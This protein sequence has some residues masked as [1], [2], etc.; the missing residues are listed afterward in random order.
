MNDGH[1]LS[2]LVEYTNVEP[3][4]I[5]ELRAEIAN[6]ARMAGLEIE[7]SCD[8]D[9]NAEIVII[10]EAPGEQERKQGRPLVG[11]SGRKLWDTLRK[12]GITRQQCYITNVVKRQVSLSPDDNS[13]R[14]AHKSEVQHWAG[15]LRWEL[16]ILPKARF[17]LCLGGPA[18][19]AVANDGRTSIEKFR[20][21]VEQLASGQT[22][23]FAY[24]PAAVLRQPSQE[25]AFF[26]DCARF[27]RVVEGR[28]KAPT[29]EYKYNLSPKEIYDE[30]DRLQDER[31]PVSYDIE[32]LG[33]ETACI[34]FTNSTRQGTCINFRSQ[35]DNLYSLQEE[36]DIR[37]RIERLFNNKEVRFVAQNG[38]FDAY[39]LWFKDRIKVHA[40]WFDTM[41]AHHLLYPSMPHSLAFLTTM[42][43]WHSFYKDDG[44]EWKDDGNI[45]KFW[46]YNIKDCC[47]TLEVHK[48]LHE[49]LKKEKMED[50]FFNHVMKI[51]PH[52]THMTVMGVAIDAEKKWQITQESSA[53]VDEL[54]AKFHEAAQHATNESEDFRPNPSSPPQLKDLY[55]N[56]LHLVGRG[57]STD[58]ANRKRML[59]NQRTP[60]S[61]REVLRAQNAYAKERKF[62]GTYAEMRLDQDGRA[63]CEWKQTGV[64][65]APGRLSSAQTLWGTGGNMQ[66]QPERAKPMYI[67]DDGYDF[68]YFDLAQAEARVVAYLAHID[69]WKEQFEKARLGSGFDC[70][71]ALASEMFNIPYDD[72]P[73][74]DWKDD[75]S[76]T[77]RYVAKRCRHG[78]NYRMMW[79]R[80]AETLNEDL[81]GDAIIS[82]DEAR[83]LWHIY[84][85]TTPQIQK[86]WAK[87]EHKVRSDMALYTPFG[88]RLKFYGRIDETQLESVVAFVPQ[89]TI[90]DKVA[91][92]IPRINEHDDWPRHAKVALNIH[93]AL[94]A[95]VPSDEVRQAIRVMK[96][97]A[98]E[99]ILV[100]GEPLIIP[101]DFAT[102]LD[103]PRE[104]KRWATMK[105]IKNYNEF[106][107]V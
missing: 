85:R 32:C 63:R 21:S 40:N 28:Y 31:L 94:I 10:A 58:E 86:W 14:V 92:C 74:E 7:C 72:V 30:L 19:E 79:D 80:L 76:P 55:F 13:R 43:T 70:H 29:V 16:S 65:R 101:A 89:S 38:N 39:W 103:V 81:E 61:A 84:H 37:R 2:S 6:R 54:L 48:R 33:G 11:G 73:K 77:I 12:V 45:D 50:L 51:Q 17:I 47:V 41:L 60:P 105:K 96:E 104:D 46:E 23:V 106:M 49:E 4:S 52:L 24:N 107:G 95:L 62:F 56:R 26:V 88:R 75:R 83:R 3:T 53:K 87:T 68:V 35:F 66:N 9:F 82:L 102:T 22:V 59:E 36:L 90:G 99:P 64:A 67:P 25:P 27:K 15:I 8:G 100:E 44:K 5:A 42:Y 20:G 78:L 18:M 69:S 93:D 34:G 71:R 57:T 98:E 97:I 1:D 91:G